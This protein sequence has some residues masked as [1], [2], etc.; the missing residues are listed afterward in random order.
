MAKN[1][2]FDNIGQAPIGSIVSYA[3]T[4]SNGWIVC[5]GSAVSQT[6]YAELYSVIGNTYETFG[7]TYKTKVDNGATD[8]KE[9][10]WH[11]D[12]NFIAAPTN[13]TNK[14][15]II[16]SFN[17]TTL[18]EVESVNIDGSGGAGQDVSWTH[19]GN[20]LA[21]GTRISG[22]ELV[23]YSWNGSDTLTEEDTFSYG[24]KIGYNLSFTSDDAFLAVGSDKTSE[25]IIVYSFN[26]VDTLTAV[27]TV[28]L[29][30][31]VWRCI[32][33]PT[34][35]YLAVGLV[36]AAS[37]E[38]QV[39]SW[40][41]SDTL[42]YVDGYAYGANV[43]GISWSPDSDYIFIS[44]ENA[45]KEIAVYSFN[46][47]TLAEVETV[48]VGITNNRTTTLIDN[49]LIVGFY[50][51]SGTT[52]WL[53][54]YTWN[55]SDTLTYDCG[56]TTTATGNC[57]GAASNN[58]KY[59]VSIATGESG[60]TFNLYTTGLPDQLTEFQLPDVSDNIIRSS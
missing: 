13:V 23:L 35:T 19:D 49:T 32:W 3:F 8:G 29:S 16:Y 34:D 9:P 25:Q 4:P 18:T 21:L 52:E 36:S 27:E 14:G 1:N 39:F 51:S 44:G 59:F 6:T 5:D 56:I 26:G 7:L 40:N 33:D 54:A 11:P 12:D 24:G 10:E 53:K 2:N 37:E 30:Y 58:G 50:G 20:F 46:G 31:T 43:T 48:D 38:L 42:S 57:R 17:G 47:T 22:K 60:S 55:G 15:L 45:S 28:D 41:G